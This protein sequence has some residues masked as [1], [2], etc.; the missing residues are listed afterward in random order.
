MRV[1]RPTVDW[2]TPYANAIRGQERHDDDGR[3]CGGP[4]PGS[5]T[6][7]KGE[8]DLGMPPPRSG[9][10]CP[11]LAWTDRLDAVL[12]VPGLG[13]VRYSLA[14]GGNFY[15]MVDLDDVGLPFDRG[16]QRDVVE[17]GLAIMAAINATDPSPARAVTIKI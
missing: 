14:F 16:R 5:E 9:L 11:A 17:A 1:P 7:P 8:A 13:D 15:A 6:P 3:R 2:D 12:P 10:P 4:W